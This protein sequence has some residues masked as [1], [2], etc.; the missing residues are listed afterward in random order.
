MIIVSWN[1]N[2]WGLP[3]YCHEWLKLAK[4]VISIFNAIPEYFVLYELTNVGVMVH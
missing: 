3:F 2:A 4:M 1:C